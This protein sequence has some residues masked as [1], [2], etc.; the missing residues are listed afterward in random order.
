M[1]AMG[2]LKDSL[3]QAVRQMAFRTSVDDLKK[4]GVQN[5]NVLG[6]DRIIQLVEEAVHRSLKSRLVGMDR[7]AVAESTKAE[8]L[9]LLRSKED[10]E[11]EKS[12]L[13]RLKERAEEEVDALRRELERQRKALQ[14]RLEQDDLEL[15]TRYAGEDAAIAAKV[16]ETLRALAASSEQPALSDAR[17]KILELVMSVISD[18][19]REAENARAAL[20]DREVD[21]LQRRIRKLGESLEQTER[22]LKEVSAMKDIDQGISSIYREVQGLSASDPRAERKREMMAE[23]FRANLQL[24]KRTTNQE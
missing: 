9:K 13:E 17:D 1:K 18:E 19:R 10:L 22:R 7:E 14:I 23:I 5:V 12:E 11:R 2:G 15:Q 6:I 4:K 3:K 16:T 21:I 20:K 8:F 24:Q